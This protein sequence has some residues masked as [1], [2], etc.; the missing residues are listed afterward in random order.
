MKIEN[1]LDFNEV[2]DRSFNFLTTMVDRKLDLLPYWLIAIDEKPAWA[3]HYRVDDAELVGSWAEAL[4]RLRQM[5][6]SKVGLECEAAFK[7]LT[8]R[9]CAENGLRYNHKYPW[10]ET[11]FCN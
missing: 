1:K 9:D 3:R 11:Q 5:T 7:R 4:I 6:G 10:T 2:A 8:L